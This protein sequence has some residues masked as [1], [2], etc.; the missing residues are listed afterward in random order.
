MVREAR[1]IMSKS[2]WSP[3]RTNKA[4]ALQKLKTEVCARQPLHLL[5]GEALEVGHLAFHLLAGG[6]GSGAD[7]LDAQLEF[8]GVRGAGQS[9]VDGDELLGVEIEE[10]LIEGLHALLAGA[11][12]DGVVNQARFVRIDDAVT[13]VRGGDHDFDRGNAAFV[14]GAAH[15]ALGNDGLQRGGE[16]QTNLLLLGRRKDRDNTL[17]GFGGVESVQGG[18]HKV[19]GFG[20]EQ[21]GRNGFEVAHFADENHVR[22]LTKSGAQGGG[23]VGGVDFDFALIDEAFF[24]AVQELDGVFDGDDVVG[25]RGVDAVDD[26]CES[27]GLTGTGGSGD[28]HEA[29]LLFAN[30]VDDRRKI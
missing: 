24:I 5:A 4:A 15:Q 10:R 22:V 13:N 8:V 26:A 30:F 29:A 28:E 3:L 17:N 25:A 21:S 14:V 20:G 18:E 9:F 23:E 2:Y 16:L 12:G 6:V 1:E 11:G 27:S 7:A 19:A